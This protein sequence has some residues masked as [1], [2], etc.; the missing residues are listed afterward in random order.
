M[1]RIF[2][3]IFCVLQATLQE[4]EKELGI[5]FCSV[6]THLWQLIIKKNYVFEIF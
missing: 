3:Q 6:A 1:L 2:H 4:L 5:N